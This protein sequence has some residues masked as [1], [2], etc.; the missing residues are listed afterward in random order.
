MVSTIG[1]IIIGLVCLAAGLG[2]GLWYSSM[3]GSADAAK[4]DAVQQEFDAYRNKVDLH[5]MDT[6]KHFAAI[7]QEYRALYEHMA[8]GAE[9]LLGGDAEISQLSFPRIAAGPAAKTPAEATV[10]ITAERDERPVT[11]DG[12]TNAALADDLEVAAQTHESP[13]E[14]TPRAAETQPSFAA[15][16]TEEPGGDTEKA[17]AASATTAAL[18]DESAEV[19]ATENSATSDASDDTLS[20]K[21]SAIRIDPARHNGAANAD[22]VKLAN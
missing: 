13:A 10:D 16:S 20:D 8:S 19:K 22:A 12:D 15:D 9:D 2:I 11:T 1:I 18:D 7:G 3:S 6:A 5:F 21:P 4:A 14:D 17:E